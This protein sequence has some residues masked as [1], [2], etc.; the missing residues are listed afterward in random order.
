MGPP[1]W[2]LLALE[3]GALALGRGLHARLAILGEQRAHGLLG[4]P[5]Q[6][7]L[8][9]APVGAVDGLL[10]RLDGQRPVRGDLR[11]QLGRAR[12]SSPAG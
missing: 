1:V 5:E 2:V 7:G 3:V 11:G 6:P 8:A 4:L 9:L 12:P 10:G